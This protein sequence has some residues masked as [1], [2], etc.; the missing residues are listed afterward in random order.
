MLLDHIANKNTS[1]VRCGE[2]EVYR[3]IQEIQ[4]STDYFWVFP[5]EEEY[6]NKKIT[7]A[8]TFKLSEE[9]RSA[10]HKYND[11]FYEKAASK[12]FKHNQY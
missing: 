8:Y 2:L 3:F 7:Y 4:Y 11:Y 10:I 9:S 5:F 1:L 6:E 12:I